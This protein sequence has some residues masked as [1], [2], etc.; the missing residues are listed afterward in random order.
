MGLISMSFSCPKGKLLGLC[1]LLLENITFFQGVL[2]LILK[3]N[4][5]PTCPFGED[6][7]Y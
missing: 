4:N 7:D 5:F 6:L 2:Q 3:W 1:P